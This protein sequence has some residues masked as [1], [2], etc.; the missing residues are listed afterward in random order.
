MLGNADTQTLH[1]G[2]V[3]TYMAIPALNL[4]RQLKLGISEYKQPERQR[5]FP[6]HCQI[7]FD[8]STGVLISP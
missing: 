6:H 1:T 2:H 3:E 5:K 4:T 8:H 7:I